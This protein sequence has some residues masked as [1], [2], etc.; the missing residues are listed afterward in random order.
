MPLLLKRLFRS[1]SS[2]WQARRRRRAWARAGAQLR[3]MD[4][5][6]LRDLGIGAGEI[7]FLLDAQS[8]PRPRP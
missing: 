4:A 5:A 8:G 2:A 3:G 1:L 6:G 7:E